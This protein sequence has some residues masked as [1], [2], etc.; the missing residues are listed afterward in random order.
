MWPFTALHLEVK[1]G[2]L[3]EEDLKKGSDKAL[4]SRWGSLSLSL[5]NG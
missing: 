2:N 4:G 1:S 3:N 5:G